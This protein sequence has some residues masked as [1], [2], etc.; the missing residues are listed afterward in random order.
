MAGMGREAGL[1]QWG[2][3]CDAVSALS[4]PGDWAKAGIHLRPKTKSLPGFPCAL[5]YF[6]AHSALRAF[7]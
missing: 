4:F 1:L 5:S 7:L 2:L 3:R 6:L